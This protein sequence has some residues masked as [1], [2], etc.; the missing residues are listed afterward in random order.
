MDSIKVKSNAK[1]NLALA[2]KNKREDGFHEIE[3]IYQEI[4]FYDTLTLRKSFSNT[5]SS[6]ST[7][8][9]NEPNNLCLTAANFLKDEFD[10]PGLEIYL[11]KRLPI[12]SGLGGGSS[13]AAS[14]L[15]GGLELYDVDFTLNDIKSIAERIGSDVSFFLYGGTAYGKGR[16]EILHSIKLITD[17]YILLV[18]PDIQISTRWAY[19]NL[20]LTLTRKNDDYKF[21]GFAFQ[22]LDLIDFRSKFYNDF[23]N[24]VFKHHPQL[25]SVKAELYDMSAEYASLSGSG[26]ALFGLFASQSTA[27][28][29]YSE[30]RQRVNCLLC[31]PVVVS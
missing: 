2:V 11:Q 9:D 3:L 12:G 14:V 30:L 10:I 27:E 20:N 31:Q 5:F 6:D 16:G 1:I 22:N 18:L 23:E 28:E 29:A 25:A 7:L 4:D 21:R 17:Y 15:T 8:L 13:N 26:S 19:K 24:L